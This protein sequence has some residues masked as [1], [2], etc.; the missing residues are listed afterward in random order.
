M[1]LAPLLLALVN[2]QLLAQTTVIRA[3]R[4]LDP[5]TGSVATNQYIVVENRRIVAVGPTMPVLK[6]ARTIDL[7]DL[8]VL[9]GL[10]DAHV[11]LVIG[12]P[13][14]DNALAVVRAGF[15]TVVDLGARTTRLL[16][17]RDSINAG[18]IPGP[19]VLAAGIWIGTKN[20]VCEFNGIGIEGGP[21]A[22]RSR[23]K[24]N[25]AGG[26]DAIKVC[27]SGWP[28]DSY[29]RPDA[30]EIAEDALQAVV[31]EA[32]AARRRVV[33]H[34]ISR[35]AARAA[36]RAGVDGLA[37]A[38]FLDSATASQMRER[39]VFLIPTL[40]SLTASD[41]SIV[42]RALVE[43]TGLAYRSAVVLVFGTDGGVL[44]HG[45]NAEEFLALEAAGVTPLDAIRS[46]TVNAAR[47]LQ[48]SDSVGR[49]APGMSA[50]VIA[51]E[52]DPLSDLESLK[53]VRFVMA[54]GQVIKAR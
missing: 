11:H 7:S 3:G 2:A 50:D 41:S 27:V 42:S 25:V 36:V 49:I 39:R 31:A 34:A 1:R 9:P 40:A 6:D 53:R 52:G 5:T 51:V 21:D 15:T 12:G 43:A 17:I 44:P 16:R 23:V 38:A 54:R 8:T 22:F 19:R 29:A 33:A 13:V 14:R 20:G 45:Q 18:V 28:G 46:A 35:G 4:L 32:H 30:F 37:H 47:A 10:V 24:E 26:A 48:L